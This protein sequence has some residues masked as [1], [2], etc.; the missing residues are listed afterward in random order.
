MQVLFQ[1]NGLK[2]TCKGCIK[3]KDKFIVSNE[4]LNMVNFKLGSDMKDEIFMLLSQA[5]DKEVYYRST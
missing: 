1:W 4:E 5:W 3:H 2:R